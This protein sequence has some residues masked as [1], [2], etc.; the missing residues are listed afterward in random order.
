[1]LFFAEIALLWNGSHMGCDDFHR[2]RF[3]VVKYTMI[4]RGFGIC[5]F[6]YFFLFIVPFLNTLILV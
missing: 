3:A 6:I 4:L 1:M 5:L 2:D